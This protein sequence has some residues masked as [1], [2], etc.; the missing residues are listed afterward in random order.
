MRLTHSQS[1]AEQ[2]YYIENFSAKTA[3][4]EIYNDKCLLLKEDFD[5]YSRTFIILY[6]NKYI[7]VVTDYQVQFVKT[8][9]PPLNDTSIINLLISKLNVLTS[10]TV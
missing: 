10:K 7:R 6:C 4:N 3:L 8:V 1:R 9:L 2:R 5:K